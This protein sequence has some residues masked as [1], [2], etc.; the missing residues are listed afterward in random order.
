MLL[1]DPLP[2]PELKHKFNEIETLGE[3][4]VL[5]KMRYAN[6]QGMWTPPLTGTISCKRIGR[7]RYAAS[8]LSW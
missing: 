7:L 8:V 2:D 6:E 5:P 1:K 4:P 3:I